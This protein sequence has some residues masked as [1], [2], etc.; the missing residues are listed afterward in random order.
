MPVDVAWY[1]HSCFR[2]NAR[3]MPSI[4]MDPFDDGVGYEALS[5]R[6]D[7]LTISHEH[8]DHC[9]RKA[10]RGRTKEI[11]GPGEYEIGGLF[12][13][14]VV[15]YHDAK[16]GADRGKNTIYFVD[17][18]D[19]KFLHLGDLGQMPTEP[20]VESFDDVDV[21]F[22][23]VGGG[24]TINAAQAAEVVSMLEPKIVVPMHY[25]TDAIKGS[26]LDS[27]TKFLKAM[28]SGSVEPVESLRVSKGELPDE[29]TVMLL[30]YK[31]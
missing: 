25:R 28:G 23:P 31:H 15:T 17:Y 19:A 20:Q 10:I 13:T 9:N 12:I 24:P 6:A 4:V 22:I 27:V 3:G 7:V 26:K 2:L 5:L 30:T 16:K 21:L 8:G 29:T 18:G 14:G 1:G 11:C